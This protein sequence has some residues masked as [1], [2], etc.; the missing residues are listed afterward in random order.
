MKNT[1]GHSSITLEL[2]H[3]SLTIGGVEFFDD[4]TTMFVAEY[5]W[6]NP[7]PATEYEA[8]CLG[9]IQLTSIQF[10]GI[11]GK[12][13][14]SDNNMILTVDPETDLLEYLA[15]SMQIKI[16][17]YIKRKLKDENELV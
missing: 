6:E 4:N 9:G 11:T 1:N 5:E 17:S 2:S 16:E 10:S 8:E 15:D 12:K 14:Y 7:Y 3:I 13:F